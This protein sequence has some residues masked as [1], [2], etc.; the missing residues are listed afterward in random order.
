MYWSV[1][2]D[3]SN[4]KIYRSPTGI[5][6][7]SALPPQQLNAICKHFDENSHDLKIRV[8]Y[9]SA[10]TATHLGLLVLAI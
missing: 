2:P 7:H 3:A 10:A 6:V 8:M 9:F 4:F 5:R 1:H